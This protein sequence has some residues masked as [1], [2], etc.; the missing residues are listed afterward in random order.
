[1]TAFWGCGFYGVQDTLH[2]VQGR[3]YFKDCHIQG[4]I[5]FI[6]GMAKSIYE[7]FHQLSESVAMLYALVILNWQQVES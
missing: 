5:G 6:F 4:S 2:D 3:H 7:V 1:M